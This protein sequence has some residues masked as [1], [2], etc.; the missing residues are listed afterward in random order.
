MIFA[1]QS[2]AMEVKKRQDLEE[3]YLELERRQCKKDLCYLMEKVLGYG[4]LAPVHQEVAEE[5]KKIKGTCRKGMFLLPRGHLKSTEITISWLIQELLNDP[6]KRILITNALLDN[7]KGFLREIKSHMERNERFRA[8]FGN[9]KNDEEKWSETQ[10]VIRSRTSFSKEPSIQVTSVDKSVVSQHYD[11]IIADDVHNRE[12]SQTKE[13]REAIKKYYKDLLD[14]LEPEG[15]MI[16]VGTRWHYDDCY[17]WLME[18]SVKNETMR[19][20]LRS[21]WEHEDSARPLYPQKFSAEY[22]RQLKADKGSSEFNAQYNNN[23]VS[24]EDAE[25]QKGWLR[26]FDLYSYNLDGKG[27]YITIDPAVSKNESADFTGFS[28]VATDAGKWK[29]LEA[30]RAKLNPTE[31]V[32]EIF[33]LCRKYR[34][35]LK[36]VGIEDMMYTSAIDY[37]ITRRMQETGEWF[38]IEKVKHKGRKKEN[39][40]RS[41]IPLFERGNIELSE[42]CT[43]LYEELEE[44]PSGRHDDVLDAFAYQL[45]II[46]PGESVQSGQNTQKP[47][48]IF[49]QPIFAQY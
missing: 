41:L 11:I 1:M 23:P 30:Y 35:N 29:V 33:H 26:T 25:F 39:R 44:F 38:S 45:D 47:R 13:Q 2:N 32:D 19:L 14:L 17:G 3:L 10:I 46:K 9:L 21:V 49:H 22:I 15:M 4:N 48:K 28:V 16:V 7:S 5:L 6:N 18:H 36:K 34:G 42:K 24:D 8:L 12:N 37:D 27:I 31:L 40:I 20:M 43:D